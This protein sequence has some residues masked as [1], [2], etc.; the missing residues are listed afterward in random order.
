MHKV[1]WVTVAGLLALT[2]VAE[3]QVKKWVDKRGTAHY[4]NVR[5]PTRVPSQTRKS[6]RTSVDPKALIEE[7]LEISGA[8][9]HMAQIAAAAQAQGA[10]RKREM[11]PEDYRQL[12]QVIAESYRTGLLYE[13]VAEKFR[14]RFDERRFV[15]VVRKLRT[16]LFR[17]ITQLEVQ[18]STPDAARRVQQFSAKLTRQPPAESR[19]ALV[20]SVDAAAGVSALNLEVMVDTVRGITLALERALPPDK[21][22][23]PGQLNWI[24]SG[25]LAQARTGVRDQTAAHLLYAYQSLTDEELKEYLRFLESDHGRWFVRV[26]REALSA[27]MRV[28]AER[29]GRGMI[30][31]LQTRGA[32]VGATT[33]ATAEKSSWTKW[34]RR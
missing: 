19:L 9:A 32:T 10:S 1:L 4:S 30:D 8:R 24:L 34:W 22:L 23:P 25:M 20:R 14:V 12:S 26:S 6:T 11:T 28:A 18:A 7:L 29:T 15:T 5:P 17:K 13:T 21:R 2:C 31:M 16:P 33:R 3:A 27:A